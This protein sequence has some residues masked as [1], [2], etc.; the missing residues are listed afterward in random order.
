M[1]IMSTI[2]S[3]VTTTYY[4]QITDRESL[5]LEEQ[6]VWNRMMTQEFSYEGMAENIAA[7]KCPVFKS[8]CGDR[9]VSCHKPCSQIL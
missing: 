1:K 5:F 9:T 2:V 8:N 7:G 6:T 3:S 4:D